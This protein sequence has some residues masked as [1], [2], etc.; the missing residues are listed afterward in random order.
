MC[1]RDR[2]I[3][4]D[5]QTN[6]ALEHLGR[7]FRRADDPALLEPFV[8]RYH[9]M[10]LP[11]FGQ[12]SFALAER[13]VK[14]FYP[15]DLASVALRDRTRRWLDEH[16]E[17]PAGLRRLVIEQLALVETAVA[18]QDRACRDEG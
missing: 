2:A 17:A 5:G 10:L 8:E 16:G 12:R 15:L 11:V 18:A 1:I 3:D 9:A 13:C 14:Y 7:G 4:A 6:A